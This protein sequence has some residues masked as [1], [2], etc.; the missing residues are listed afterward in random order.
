M[1]LVISVGSTITTLQWLLLALFTV[2][3][4][5]IALGFT[6]AIAGFVLLMN[7]RKP[8]ST[9]PLAGRT[10]LLLPIYNEP[11][12]RVFGRAEAMLLALAASGQGAHFELVLLSDSTDPALWIAEERGVHAPARSARRDGRCHSRLVSPPQPQQS[13]ENRAMSPSS[14]GHTARAMI[15]C[16]CSTPTA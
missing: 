16:L 12:D 14:S 7:R 1:Y 11:P 5:W 6:S 10:A 9:A 13:P 3:F 15:I 2:N 8:E 4:S